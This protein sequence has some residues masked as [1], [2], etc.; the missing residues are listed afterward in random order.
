VIPG[1][2]SRSSGEYRRQNR[3]HQ[4]RCGLYLFDFVDQ[5][6]FPLVEAWISEVIQENIEMRTRGS[7]GG[8]RAC[9]GEISNQITVS[10]SRRR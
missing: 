10:A 5:V 6:V 8:R 3:A 7:D 2:K 1:S 4:Q 9:P